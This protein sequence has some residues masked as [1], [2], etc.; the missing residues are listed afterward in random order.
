MLKFS[1]SKPDNDPEI[2]TITEKL[3]KPNGEFSYRKYSKGRFLGKGGFA[4]VYEFIN[5]ETKEMSA[6]KIIPKASLIKSRAK[7]KLMSEIKIHRSLKHENI[8]RFLHFFEDSENVYIL[9]EICS[10]QTLNELL[11]RR[12]RLTELET[13]CYLFQTL[14]AIS[15]I[16]SQR[17]IHR[18]IKLGNLLLNDKMEVKLGDF[19]LA[20]K[21]EY[22]GERKRTICGTPN[23]IAPEILDGKT[24]HSFEVD[25]WSLGV[26]AYTLMIGKPPFET[27]DVKATYRRIKMN[28]YSYPEHVSLSPSAKA[29]ISSILQSDPKLRPTVSELLDAP[30]LT[31][32]S[33]PKVLPHSTL[34]V[35]PS[36][37]YLSKY[38][39][40]DVK[41]TRALSLAGTENNPPI[42][43]P[44]VKKLEIK[45]KPQETENK[46][47][48]HPSNF[49][50]IQSDV[51]L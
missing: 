18:D 22:A 43:P 38:I 4:R 46:K 42:Q 13:Q 27:Q 51:S 6:A 48:A 31:M 33:I 35:P 50:D 28:A 8:V 37:V 23:Y 21:L 30:F 20:S 29:F 25:V 14:K 5:K 40:T 49:R 32:N 7:Q 36:T 9:L 24:G 11:R 2:Q 45:E 26:L 15:H 19:G 41:R 1:T 47:T 17:I 39:E 3:K 10:N 12:K 16:H 34:A 44:P